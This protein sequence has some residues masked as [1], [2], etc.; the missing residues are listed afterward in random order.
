TLRAAVP[1]AVVALAVA[2]VLAVRLV[3]LVVVRNQIAQREAV[4]RRHEVDARERLAPVGGIEIR[5]A[6]QPVRE[7]AQPP[8][9]AA[10]IVARAVA[11]LAVPLRPVRRE[12]ADLIAAFA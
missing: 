1:G 2:V 10:P 7:L 12:V 3:V 4:V 11:I 6:A 8:V 9:D 5:A